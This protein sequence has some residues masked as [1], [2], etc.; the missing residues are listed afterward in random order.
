MDE[1]IFIR[2]QKPMTLAVDEYAIL[3]PACPAVLSGGYRPTRT[4]VRIYGLARGFPFILNEER[5]KIKSFPGEGQES[6]R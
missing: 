6:F 1:S 5:M 4:Q 3:W 2:Q